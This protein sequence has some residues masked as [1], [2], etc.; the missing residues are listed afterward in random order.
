MP[1]GAFGDSLS[2]M[3][4]AGGIA[5]ALA[6]KARTGEGALVDG[7]LLGTAMW[8]MQMGIVGAAVAGLDEM[9][10]T[11][12]MQTPNPLVNTYPT[13]DG[14]WVALCM[15][16]PDVYWEPFVRAIGR[17]DLLD[18]PR[19]AT[20][21]DRAANVAECVTTLDE[22][23]AERTLEEWKP[24]LASQPGQWDVVKRVS[25]LLV[26]PQ[27]VENR[28]VQTVDYGEGREL[29]L[30]RQSRAVRPHRARARTGARVRRRHRRAV[31]VPRLGLGPHHRGEGLR[32]GALNR[33][34]PPS[35][36]HACGTPSAGQWASVQPS[37]D[38]VRTHPR[39]AFVPPSTLMVAPVT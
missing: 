33:S 5:A 31:V 26:D 22:T 27:A 10:K 9:P 12:R 32:R 25:E 20:S 13:A 14:R 8:S 1:A 39:A 29:P 37:P 38:A 15:L 4:L 30:D 19:F 11:T 21:A 16:Q 24:V 2:G 6:H 17:E 18:D 35:R 3:A 7:S 36:G 23:F 34:P 28:F